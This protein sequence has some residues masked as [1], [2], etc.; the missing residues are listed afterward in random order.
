MK[1]SYEVSILFI[2]M[3]TNLWMML[4]IEQQNK[5]SAAPQ[6][7][8]INKPDSIKDASIVNKE[9]KAVEILATFKML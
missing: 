5:K 8:Q 3:I 7:Q 9:R 4:H 2:V 1:T 6:R